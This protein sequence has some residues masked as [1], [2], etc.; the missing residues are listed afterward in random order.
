MERA[1]P[2]DVDSISHLGYQRTYLT[3]PLCPYVGLHALLGIRR[4]IRWVFF[5]QELSNDLQRWGDHR[6]LPNRGGRFS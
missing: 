1:M 6:V 3:G 2:A 5:G 4:G